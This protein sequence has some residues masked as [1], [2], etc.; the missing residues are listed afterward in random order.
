MT[1]SAQ[2]KLVSR[3][4]AEDSGNHPVV[5]SENNAAEPSQRGSR[6]YWTS[7]KGRSVVHCPSSYGWPM[8]YHASSIRIEVGARWLLAHPI[9]RVKVAGVIMWGLSAEIAYLHGLRITRGWVRGRRTTLV[10]GERSYHASGWD[11]RRAVREAI[12][13]W[14]RQGKEEREALQIQASLSRIWV[15]AADSSD[16]GNCPRGT[17][18]V[19]R[20]LAVRLGATGADLG[21]VRA[22]YL[23]QYRN[24]EYTWRAVR[25]AARRIVPVIE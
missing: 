5:L 13:A 4:W 14:R 12:T 17:D 20:K 23:L 2:H 6:H 24:D 9:S 25:V 3:L 10:D 11:G 16:A 21:A 8:V 22:D 19:S 7:L 1:L 18:F 15:S